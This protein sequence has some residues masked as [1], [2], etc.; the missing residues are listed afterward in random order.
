MKLWMDVMRGIEHAL[1]HYEV[2]FDAWAAGGVDGLVIGPLAFGAGVLLNG[3]R[4]APDAGRPTATFDPD[5]RVYRRFGVETPPPAEAEPG[6]RQRLERMLCAAKDRGWSVWIFGAAHGAGPGGSGPLLADS[7]SQAAFTARM[8]DT[9]EHYPMADGAIMDGPEWGYEIAPQHMNRR[10]NIF[11]DL[12]P[13]VA[14]RCAELGYDY[15]AL[16]AAQQR[17]LQ[18]LQHLQPARVALH[19]PGGWLGAERLLGGDPDLSAWLGFRC[20]SLTAFFRGVRQG[21]DAALSRKARLGLGPRSPAFAPLCGY[22]LAELAAYIDILLPKHYFWQRGFDGMLGTVYRTVETLCEWNPELSDTLA[23][24]VV[25]AL[26][27]LHLPGVQSR[28]DLEGALSPAFYETIVAQET[29]RALAVVADPQR[30][31]PWVDAGRAPHDGDPFPARDLRRLLEAAQG[32]GL[33]RF[34]YHHQ[35]KLTAGEWTV[36]SALCGEPWQPTKSAYRP[37]EQFVL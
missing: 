8:V 10:S 37:A 15:R 12:P 19:A 13:A 33:P 2:A 7:L 11:D 1:E 14:P 17:L 34:L 28:L 23:L 29:A 5:P 9:L 4:W 31:V 24:A 32:A 3:V 25:Q 27:G 26:F 36:I 18:R 35:A 21:V 30:I 22:D 20:Q 6:K 16:L